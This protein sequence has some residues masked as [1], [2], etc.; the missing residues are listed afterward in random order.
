MDS[1]DDFVAKHYIAEVESTVIQ[2]LVL[3]NLY[4]LGFGT[5]M[6]LFV[7]VP[8]IGPIVN[9]LTALGA[10]QYIEINS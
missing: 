1:Y 8:V 9:L 4:N 10:W 3:F 6:G 2:E 7:P 5:I